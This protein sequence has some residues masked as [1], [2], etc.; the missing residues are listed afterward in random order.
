MSRI[1]SEKHGR[2]PRAANPAVD[3][4]L[5]DEYGLEL[6]H[7]I[8]C[9]HGDVVGERASKVPRWELSSY[10]HGFR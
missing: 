7:E 10:G 2:H 5:R 1:P 4:V 6:I 9:R 8:H 3:R